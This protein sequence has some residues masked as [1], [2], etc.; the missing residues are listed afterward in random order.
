VQ[1]DQHQFHSANAPSVARG[2]V[3]MLL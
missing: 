2:S 1:R 3:S